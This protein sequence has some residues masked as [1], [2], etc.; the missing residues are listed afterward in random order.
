ML[1]QR[2][3]RVEGHE[4]L[5]GDLEPVDKS[6]QDEE[7]VS[8][9]YINKNQGWWIRTRKKASPL[10]D[11]CTIFEWQE[12]Q[13]ELSVRSN[14]LTMAVLTRAVNLLKSAREAQPPNTA[15]QKSTI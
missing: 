3:Q 7:P 8:A 4:R 11:I 1:Q 5:D 10:S 13:K 15:L 14:L 2:A 6:G 9:R 12:L